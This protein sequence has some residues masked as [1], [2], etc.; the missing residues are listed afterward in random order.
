MWPGRRSTFP[1]IG[2]NTPAT[3]RTKSVLPPPFGPQ[4]A[5]TSPCWPVGSTASGTRRPPNPPIDTALASAAAQGSHATPREVG[6]ARCVERLFHTHGRLARRQR[7]VLEPEGHLAVDSVINGLQL[8]VP[9]DKTPGPCQ[10]AGRSPDHV[11]ALDLRPSRD[12]A[13][14]EMWNQAGQDTQQRRLPS[15]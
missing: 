7:D 1:A 13:S 4:R 11:L 9:E 10:R 8:G 15:A 5:I 14:V 3:S 2:D 6:C 12:A